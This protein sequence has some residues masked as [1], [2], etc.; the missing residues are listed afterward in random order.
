L[1]I[2]MCPEKLHLRVRS[3]A[4]DQAHIRRAADWA[5]RG[6]SRFAPERQ[7]LGRVSSVARRA[8]QVG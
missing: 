4:C 3:L 8:A 5:K 6:R 1:V 7:Q 2:G